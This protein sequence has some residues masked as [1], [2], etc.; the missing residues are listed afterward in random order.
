[1]AG[2]ACRRST[3]TVPG[4]GERRWPWS[5]AAGRERHARVRHPRSPARVL[6]GEGDVARGQEAGHGERRVD[7]RGASRPSTPHPRRAQASATSFCRTI[8]S[9]GQA[10]EIASEMRRFG[11]RWVRLTFPGGSTRASERPDLTDPAWLDS[12]SFEHW[13]DAFRAN[14]IEVLGVLFGMARWAS[15]AQRS[16][17]RC[18]PASRRGGSWRRAIRRTGSCSSAR[19]PDA[20]RGRVARLGSVERA[21]HQRLLAVDGRRVRRPRRG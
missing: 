20:L 4:R 9:D 3:R 12:A 8:P 10:D 14:G 21:R 18:T 6:H 17:R 5:L 15:S 19:W 11:I 1:M 2:C 13:V 7:G 16:A